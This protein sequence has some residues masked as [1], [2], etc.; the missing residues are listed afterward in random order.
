M[1]HPAGL[2]ENVRGLMSLALL[3][4][5]LV[6][7]AGLAGNL[8]PSALV[9]RVNEVVSWYS[10]GFN[11]VPRRAPL[12]MTHSAVEDD[13]HVVQV[14]TPEG[15]ERLVLPGQEQP[16]GFRWSRSRALAGQ[17]ARYVAADNQESLSFLVQ[18]LGHYGMHRLRSERVVVRCLRLEPHPIDARQRIER[19]AGVTIYEADVF[20]DRRGRPILVRRATAS[21]VAPSVLG[22]QE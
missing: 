20:L 8:A 16:G 2:S 13:D 7:F 10:H 15:R 1:S 14:E 22:G 5:L 18:G 9:A 12:Y 11:L 17:L 6:V 3:A 4:H 21:D 19:G